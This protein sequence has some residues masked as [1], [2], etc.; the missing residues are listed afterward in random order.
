M[1]NI[2]ILLSPILIMPI[3]YWIGF[4]IEAMIEWKELVT[5][6]GERNVSTRL[7]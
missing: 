4:E 1:I 3:A 6:D 7:K 2:L 5:Q